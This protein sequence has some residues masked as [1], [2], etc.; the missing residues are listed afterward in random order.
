MK[1]VVAYIRHEAFDSIRQE[2]LDRGFPSLTVSEVKGS[3]RQK[4][5][6]EHYRGADLTVH[7]RPKVKLECVIEDKDV[8]LVKDV[9]VT[10]ARTGSVGDGKLFVLPVEDAV[11]L[12]T[13]EEGER[14]LQV[15]ESDEIP[16]GT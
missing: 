9:I 15:H 10:H 2:L 6:T 3:G 14:V 12:R 16:T 5:I 7:L 13:G 4:G 11:R 8:A 1:M